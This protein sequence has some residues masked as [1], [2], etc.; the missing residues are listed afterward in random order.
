MIQ[1]YW[2]FLKKM[3]TISFTKRLFLYLINIILYS[4]MGFSSSLP[5]LLVLHIPIG[6]YIVISLGVTVTLG[7]IL[8][9]LLIRI[10]RGST[11]TSFFFGV[12]YI[13][14]EEKELK[15]RQIIIRVIN[16]AIPFL[17]L[18]DLVYLKIN[19]TE[20]GVIDRISDSFT[21]DLRRE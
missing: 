1:C 4:G 17:L 7:V 10:M 12:R 20:R 14:V 6:W 9:Y 16:E 8:R 15:G 21:I 19:H 18:L 3:E 11:I 5:F 13:G 2:N